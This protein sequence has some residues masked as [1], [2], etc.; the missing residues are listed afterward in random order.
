MQIDTIGSVLEYFE[1]I[2]ARTRRVI[3]C[4]PSDKIDWTRAADRWTFA[5]LI[6]HL[7]ATE[8]FMFT[9]NALDRPSGYQGHGPALAD[10]YDAAMRT[11]RRVKS[12]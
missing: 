5:D 3:E 11:P 2:H 7:A 4:I 6:R 9:E 10:G 1:K 8:R 12:S